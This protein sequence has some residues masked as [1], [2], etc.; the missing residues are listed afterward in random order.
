[1]RSVLYNKKLKPGLPG[2]Y[3]PAGFA[4]YVAFILSSFPQVI[5]ILIQLKRR[6]KKNG[7]EIIDCL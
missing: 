3:A 1:M 7:T 4:N 5:G 2:V 6:C